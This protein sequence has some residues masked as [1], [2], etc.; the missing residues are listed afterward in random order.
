MSTTVQEDPEIEINNDG[1]IVNNI[2]ELTTQQFNTELQEA[3]QY[4]QTTQSTI[5]QSLQTLL[6]EQ[7]KQHVSTKEL[8]TNQT[9]EQ[10]PVVSEIM[11]EEKMCN[12]LIIC[13]N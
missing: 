4:D 10:P 13:Q 3:I 1:T 8:Q 12:I 5:K 11:K 7:E 9:D 6:K 2:T